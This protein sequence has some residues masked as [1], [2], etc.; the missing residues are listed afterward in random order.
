LADIVRHDGPPPL[1]ERRLKPLDMY[2]R[3][4]RIRSDSVPFVVIS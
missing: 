2:G 4:G 1:S 3:S